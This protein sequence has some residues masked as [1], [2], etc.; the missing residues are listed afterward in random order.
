MTSGGMNM[1]ST[2]VV[3]WGDEMNP[4]RVYGSYTL[5]GVIV[6]E[7]IYDPSFRVHL[8]PKV[9]GLA[10]RY[11]SSIPLGPDEER[12]GPEWVNARCPQRSDKVEV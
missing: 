11:H 8:V 4:E 10:G 7:G 9:M 3:P 2:P 1:D 5:M 6:I 12:L